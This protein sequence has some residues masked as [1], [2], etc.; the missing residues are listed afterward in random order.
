V[1][2]APVTEAPTEGA[3]KT[4]PGWHKNVN[5]P[6]GLAKKDELPNGFDNGKKVGW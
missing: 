3:V 1:T 5:L 6:K 4:P 2:E